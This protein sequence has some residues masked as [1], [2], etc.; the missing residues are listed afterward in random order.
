MNG[1][2]IRRGRAA[3]AVLVALLLAGACASAESTPLAVTVTPTPA[4]TAEATPTPS[5]A[6]TST[7]T[8]VVPTPTATPVATD[9][10]TPAPTAAP[11]SR[12]AGCTGNATNKAF[13]V[14]AS[15]ALHFAIYCAVLPKGWSI[16]SGTYQNGWL[17]VAYKK[18]GGAAIEIAEG[19]FCITSP[20]ACS[21]HTSVLGTGSFGGLSGQLDLLDPTPIYV[22]YVHPGTTRAYVIAGKGMTQANFVSYGAKMLK[23][24]SA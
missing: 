19:A 22:I 4:A 15:S 14:D 11:T 3:T 18:S 20:A 23:V 5:A 17:D 6:P 12:A 24:P 8:L 16:Q 1:N 13:F 10:P 7:P 2:A 21:T 9:T